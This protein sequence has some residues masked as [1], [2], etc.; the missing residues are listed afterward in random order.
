VYS[1]VRA[2]DAAAS[3][4]VPA[5]RERRA[6]VPG[7]RA[8]QARDARPR[9]PPRHRVQVRVAPF[10]SRGRTTR[11][12]RTRSSRATDSLGG[13]NVFSLLEATKVDF[14]GCRAQVGGGRAERRGVVQPVPG[15]EAR[16]QGQALERGCCKRSRLTMHV[17]LILLL[18]RTKQHQPCGSLLRLLFRVG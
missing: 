16:P 12:I 13:F 9:P 1:P 4:H 10:L 11:Q 15:A 6:R 14:V 7:Q 17:L 8:G 3:R 18:A 2:G 5:V